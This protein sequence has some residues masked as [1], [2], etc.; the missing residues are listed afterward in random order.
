MPPP[1]KPS[2][3][4]T[5]NMKLSFS[6]KSVD[7]IERKFGVSIENMLGSTQ[8]SNLAQFIERGYLDEDTQKVGVQ[9]E[10]SFELLQEYLKDHEKEDLLVDIMEALQEGGFLSR[11]LDLDKIRKSLIE[12][13]A[14]IDKKLDEELGKI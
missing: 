3:K 6:A 11:K 9:N 14:E 1:N 7:N 4:E 12:K 8:M 2:N 10:R 5:H 13:T